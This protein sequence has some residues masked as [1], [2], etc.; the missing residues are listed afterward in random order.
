MS[1]TCDSALRQLDWR[2]DH[3]Q[4]A[5]VRVGGGTEVRNRTRRIELPTE[6][7]AAILS[8][9]REPGVNDGRFL[10]R[11]EATVNEPGTTTPNAQVVVI[12]IPSIRTQGADRPDKCGKH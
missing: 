4:E 11:L 2:R 10:G 9:P 6:A 5:A 12:D 1:V 3:G 7:L 8:A